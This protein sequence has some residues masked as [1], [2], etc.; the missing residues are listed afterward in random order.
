[1][2]VRRV[3]ELQRGDIYIYSEGMACVENIP[4]GSLSNIIITIISI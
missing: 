2:N 1:M 4:E 3:E